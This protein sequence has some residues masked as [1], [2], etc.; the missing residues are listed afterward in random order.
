MEHERQQAL[1]NVRHISN[2]NGPSSNMMGPSPTPKDGL[3]PQQVAGGPSMSMDGHNLA[4][5]PVPHS[6]NEAE[7]IA[8]QTKQLK[9]HIFIFLDG[10]NV[11]RRSMCCCL[12]SFEIF[13]VSK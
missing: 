1:E 5:F 7:L 10:K 11:G 13:V 9:V 4:N 3:P 2:T 6:K 8:E 12:E